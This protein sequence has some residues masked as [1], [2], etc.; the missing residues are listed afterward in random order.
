MKDE[1]PVVFNDEAMN[2]LALAMGTAHSIISRDYLT[3]IHHAKIISLEASESK[4]LPQETLRL[5][6]ISTF[7][8]DRHESIIEKL[9]SMFSALAMVKNRNIIF[10]LRNKIDNDSENLELYMGVSGSSVESMRDSYSVLEHS[11]RGNFPGCQI[12]Q[13]FN[14]DIAE[15]MPELVYKNSPFGCSVSSVS[16]DAVQRGS[17]DNFVQGMEKFADSMSGQPYTL[18]LIASPVSGWEIFSDLNNLRELYTE[19][20]SYKT[21][22]ITVNETTTEGFSLTLGTQTGTTLSHSQNISRS[23]GRTDTLGKTQGRTKQ[24]FNFA[25]S[26]IETGAALL[27]TAGGVVL[28][29]PG[30]SFVG[31][32]LGRQLRDAVGSGQ[33][34][35]N[36]SVQVSKGETLQVA[37]G[38]QEQEARQEGKSVSTALNQSRNS[39]K[40]SSGKRKQTCK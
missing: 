34:S 18:I 25:G 3:H 37:E 6:R 12:S 28:G 24:E 8:Y 16:L 33:E 35:S 38:S 4:K 31:G 2:K 1:Y 15:L 19:I 13:C 29:M 21:Q 39:G 14:E 26:L 7:N 10:I 27:G 40:H 11:I 22:S 30:L 36:E 17:D 23:F 9:R 32:I 20:S 5:V